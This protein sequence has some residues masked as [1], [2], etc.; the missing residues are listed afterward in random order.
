M[1]AQSGAGASGQQSMESIMSQTRLHSDMCLQV[2][3]GRARAPLL[4]QEARLDSVKRARTAPPGTG[5]SIIMPDI[6]FLYCA[7]GS[8]TAASLASVTGE[9]EAPDIVLSYL[10]IILLYP[11]IVLL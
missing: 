11:D 3:M 10:D 6:V 1:F 2:R 4:R 8:H 9:G 7:S 5:Y